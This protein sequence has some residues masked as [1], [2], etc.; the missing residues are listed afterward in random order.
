MDTFWGLTA[1]AWTAIYT[2]LTACLLAVAVIAAWYAKRQWEAGRAANNEARK[3]QMEAMRPYVTVTVEPSQAS[4]QLFDLIIRNIGQRPALSVAIKVDPPPM[5]AA[6]RPGAEEMAQMKL[7]NEPMSIVAPGQE[8]RIFYDSQLS[9][10]DR[11]DLPTRHEATVH[12]ADSSGRTFKDSYTL[13]LEA[14]KGLRWI[15]VHNVHSIGKSLKSIDKTLSNSNTLKGENLSVHAIT[16]PYFDHR[17]R[18]VER[19]I[20]S[21]KQ[22]LEFAKQS[23]VDVSRIAFL[24]KQIANDE[25]HLA[26]LRAGRSDDDRAW[27][28]DST[29]FD[30]IRRR[31]AH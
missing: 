21:D 17:I 28:H 18:E 4:M 25:A 24:E 6:E 15:E 8:I 14:L 19:D 30:R 7:L 1:T 11:D 5:R 29:L 12:Y 20:A 31:L 3:A 26:A 22:D 10:K 16:E 9:R 13:D 27:A 2:L 23:K